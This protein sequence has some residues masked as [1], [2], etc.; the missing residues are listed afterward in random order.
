[1]VVA[2]AVPVASSSKF[3]ILEEELY[4]FLITLPSD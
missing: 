3:N 4:Y 1:M 2:I